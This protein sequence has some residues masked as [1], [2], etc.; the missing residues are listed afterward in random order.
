MISWRYITLTTVLISG[1]GDPPNPG[2]THITREQVPI[3]YTCSASPSTAYSPGY[4]FRID[5]SGASLLVMDARE[6]AQTNVYPAAIGSYNAT[7]TS[8]AGLTFSLSQASGSAKADANRNSSETTNVSF[9]NG[10]YVLM[11]DR[12]EA[13]LIATIIDEIEPRSGSRYFMVRDAIQATGVDITLSSDDELKLG[14]EAS[15]LKIVTAKPNLS[16]TRQ[17]TLK[18]SGDFSSPLNVCVRAVEI[19]LT[20][21]DDQGVA[22]VIDS[23]SGEQVDRYLA[24]EALDRALRAFE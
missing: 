3:G 6:Q 13:T 11:N 21:A 2:R 17:E 19:T 12:N 9:D 8:G 20:R 23:E 22:P 7:L 16:V 4:V 15:V 18:V 24:P 5:P 10:Q 1:C 14:G